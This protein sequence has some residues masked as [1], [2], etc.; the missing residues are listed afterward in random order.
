MGRVS[1]SFLAVL[2]SAL[3]SV[4]CVAAP[5]AG[6]EVEPWPGDWREAVGIVAVGDGRFVAWERGGLAWMVGPDGMASTEPM[7]DLTEE[8]GAWRDHGLLGLAVDPDF[9]NNGFVYLLYIVDRHHLLYAGTKAYDPAASEYNAA[10]I[11]RLTRYTATAESDRSVVDPD[12]RTILIG[13]AIDRGLPV[14]N[15]S[16]GVGALAFG[17][18]GTLLISM[19]DGGSFFQADTGGPAVGGWVEM[20]LAD[21]IIDASQD[22]GSFRAQMIDSL[23]GKILRVDPATGDGVASNP[24]F[25]PADPRADRSRVWTI[26]LRNPFRFSVIPGTGSTDPA[27]G[28]PGHIFYGDVGLGLREEIGIIDQPGLNMGWPFYEGLDANAPFWTAENLHPYL[29]NPDAADGCPSGLRFREV[30]FEEGEIPCNP[31]D[32]AWIEPSAWS[33]PA[34]SRLYG[35]WTG[36]GYLAFTSNPD[37]WIDFEF[38]VPDKALRRYGLRYS[39]AGTADRPLELVVDGRLLDTLSLPPT[40]S[41]RDWRKATF[42]LS[43]GPGTHVVRVRKPSGSAVFVD[44]LD[45]PDLSYTLLPSESSFIHRRPLL[46][47]KHSSSETRVPIFDADGVASNARLGTEG[48]PIEGSPFAGNCAVGGLYLDDS[49]WPQEWHGLF[50]GDHIYGWIRTLR[51]DADGI[52]A[53]VAEFYGG[54]G[55]VTSMTHDS[56]SGDLI[57]IRWNQNPV[58]V[59]PPPS[60]PSDIN[61]DGSTNGAD[62][63]LLLAGWGTDGPGDIN[64]DG[65]VDGGDLGLQLADFDLPP[66][67]CPGD[68]DGDGFV[69]ASDLGLL[70]GRWGTAGEGDINGDGTTDS[71]DLGLL[72][73]GFGPCPP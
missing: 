46:E 6:F 38:E 36:D 61:D 30:F 7:I 25:D 70:L 28:R 72:L 52:P 23:N 67:P 45:A 3:S 15:Q 31:C 51:L 26:G 60:D 8:V 65:T 41:W 56:I 32:P 50:F 47:W 24:W 69:T 1:S 4:T 53:E 37:E 64:G 68:L 63:G 66:S 34:T 12:S 20:G 33:G 21:G 55:Q 13:E 18:D 43:L 19:G 58:R 16:H 42:D 10:T 14:L 29:T 54:F 2:F 48:C 49:R 22:V 5:P 71:G 73:G 9:A 44:R 17:E 27:D 62:L 40:G 11:G 57:A 39:N 35:G 59:S